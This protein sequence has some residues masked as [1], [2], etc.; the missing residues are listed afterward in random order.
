MEPSTKKSCELTL[1]DRLSRLT[2]RQACKLLGEQGEKLIQRGGVWEIDI[3]EQVELNKEFF[4]LK[5]PASSTGGN[6]SRTPVVTIQRADDERDCLQWECSV[7]HTACE[8]T[9]AAFSLLLEDKMALG[10]AAAPS[11]RIPL[12]SLSDEKLIEQ[13]F[14][15]REERSRSEKMVLRSA[16]SNKLWTD[17]TVISAVSGKT[18]RLALRGWERGESFSLASHRA[19]KR[20]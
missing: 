5:L 8:H 9:G 6:G 17:Y 11:E 10:L 4:I 20:A 7:C 1:H 12:E 3:E 16:H 13:A 18:Y 2:Y 19:A 15:E 14:R